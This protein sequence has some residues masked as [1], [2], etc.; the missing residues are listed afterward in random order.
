MRFNYDFMRCPSELDHTL[1]PRSV[2][3]TSFRK[4]HRVIFRKRRRHEITYV[5][6]LAANAKHRNDIVRVPTH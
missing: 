5:G 4:Q 1:A 3:R 6:L 2:T